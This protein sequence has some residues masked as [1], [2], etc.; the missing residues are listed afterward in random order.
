ML[1]AVRATIETDGQVHLLEPLH[2][3]HSCRA[4]VTIMDEPE[5]PEAALLS[6]Q[7]LAQD[8]EKPEEDAAWSHL[9]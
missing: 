2:L 8:W 6:E 7:A 9:Q 4:I 3:P 5:A 1:K